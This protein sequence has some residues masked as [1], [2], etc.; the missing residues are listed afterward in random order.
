MRLP[1]RERERRA[2]IRIAA[3]RLADTGRHRG[4]RAIEVALSRRDER[5]VRQA[6]S[7]PLARIVINLR[8]AVAGFFRT[9]G[10]G[11]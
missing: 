7:S 6:L 9:K 10:R 5:S 1:A 3:R 8:C 4:W 11:N 2:R